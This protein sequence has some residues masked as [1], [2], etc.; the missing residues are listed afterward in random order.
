[1]HPGTRPPFER[2]LI[3]VHAVLAREAHG[4]ED[5]ARSPVDQLV[6]T[7]VPFFPWLEETVEEVSRPRGKNASRIIVV[8]VVHY[9]RLRHSSDSQVYCNEVTSARHA[10]D[11]VR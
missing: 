6:F 9:S 7:E 3:W 4:L 10:R 8:A 11:F 1:M 2:E 5:S